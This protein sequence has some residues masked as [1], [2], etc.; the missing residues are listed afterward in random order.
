MKST[1]FSILVCAVAA[2][3]SCAKLDQDST[4]PVPPSESVPVS[5]SFVA[6]PMQPQSKAFFDPAATE[7]WEKSLSSLSVFV[8]DNTGKLLIQRDFTGA[9]LSAKTATFS[10]PGATAGQSC[11]FYAVANTTA[12]NGAATKTALT[13]LLETSAAAYNGTFAEVSAAAKRAGGFVM[14]GN[15]TKAIAAAG[16]QTDVAISLKRTVAKIAL[17][18]S[19]ASDFSSKYKGSVRINSATLSKGAAQT[20][21]IAPAAPNTGAMSFTH[22][23]PSNTVSGKYQ[24]LFYVYECGALAAGNRVTLDLNATYDTDGNFSTTGDQAVVTYSVELSGKTG[25]AIDRN[26]YYRVDATINGLTGND[27]SA[28]I[29]VADWTAPVT[30]TADLGK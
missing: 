29:S 11:D 15:L 20:P 17:Q 26:G 4:Q 25:G 18:V 14:S 30:Q 1:V 24:N 9:E 21:I 27:A 12:A 19:I 22:T 16:S 10:V 7:T 13:A 8:F 28:T 3:S 23:Q 2:L 5:I 6:D